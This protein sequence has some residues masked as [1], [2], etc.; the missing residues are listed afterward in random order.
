M[1]FGGAELTKQQ[2][3]PNNLAGIEVKSC[4]QKK[5]VSAN[6][7]NFNQKDSTNFTLGMLG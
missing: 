4:F 1:L 5:N 7:N 3:Q 6:F 2:F